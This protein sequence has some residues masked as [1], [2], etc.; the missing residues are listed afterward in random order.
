MGNRSTRSPQVRH[1]NREVA[2][3]ATSKTFQQ[4][5]R[6]T[7]A[8]A[9]RRGPF[10]AGQLRRRA[11]RPWIDRLAAMPARKRAPFA[12]GL[13]TPRPADHGR[14]GG[15]LW[16]HAPARRGQ[17]AHLPVGTAGRDPATPLETYQPALGSATS[18]PWQLPEQADRFVTAGQP[19]LNGSGVP[20]HRRVLVEEATLPAPPEEVAAFD[21]AY[22]QLERHR[23]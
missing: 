12:R 16:S 15:E 23:R 14:L 5:A 2:P 18:V 9:L 11:L 8:P 7:G 20:R 22:A 6:L 13:R 4:L 17:P 3:V 19:G 10:G 21:A 1:G